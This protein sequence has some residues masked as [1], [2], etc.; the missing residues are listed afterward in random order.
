MREPAIRRVEELLE[1]E[2][3]DSKDG[4]ATATPKSIC[5]PAKT[6][7]LLVIDYFLLA[8]SRKESY[9]TNSK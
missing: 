9:S 1:G 7:F 3:G 5:K 8:I 4:T 2:L 6:N